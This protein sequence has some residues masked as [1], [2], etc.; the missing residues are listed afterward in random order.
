VTNVTFSVETSPNTNPTR[1]M[2]G[3]WHITSPRLK[4]GGTRTPCLPPNCAH[5]Q[6]H[7]FIRGKWATQ[8]SFDLFLKLEICIKLNCS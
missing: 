5:D 3:T 8:I 4:S 1:K 2:W 6:Q 7:G